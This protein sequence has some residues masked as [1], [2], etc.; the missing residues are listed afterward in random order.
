M[1]RLQDLATKWMQECKNADEQKDLIVR[2]QLINSLP[3]DVRIWVKERKPKT[4][5]E[6]G[7]LADDYVQARKKSGKEDH[8]N[9]GDRKQENK[10]RRHR[11]NKW[12]HIAK[13]CR[14][15]MREQEKKDPPPDRRKSGRVRALGQCPAGF[16][17]S[18]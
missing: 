8:G 7:A 12:G 11:C 1:V 2:E 16:L 5:E 3:D 14:A 15:E 18:S 9:A 17:I 13:E 4:S 10:Q 6:A